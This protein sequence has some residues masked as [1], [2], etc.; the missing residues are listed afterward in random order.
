MASVLTAQLDQ[1]RLARDLDAYLTQ[2]A[3]VVTAISSKTERTAAEQWLAWV[4]QYR[5]RID[6]LG[7]PEQSHR[8]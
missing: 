6:P 3:A 5:Q 8:S 7:Q 4:R 2:M 1:W